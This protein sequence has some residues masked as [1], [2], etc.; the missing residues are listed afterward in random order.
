METGAG[1]KR[2]KTGDRVWATG[3]GTAD[4][5]G[6]F[7]ELAAVDERCLYPIL[8]NEGFGP[9]AEAVFDQRRGK[10]WA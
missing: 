8:E 6:T 2:F 4:R 3:Q 10:Y 1:V 5:N 9:F 7:A